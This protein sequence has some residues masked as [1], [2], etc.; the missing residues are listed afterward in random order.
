MRHCTVFPLRSLHEEQF[1]PTRDS[2][3]AFTLIEILVVVAIIALLV[4]VLLPSLARA[5]AQGRMALCQSHE[6][7]FGV[8]ATIFA[9]EHKNKIL[10]S[11]GTYSQQPANSGKYAN[12]Y[13]WLG[14]VARMLGDK[15]NYT[16]ANANKVPVEKMDVFQCP[17]RTLTHP[18]PYLDYVVNGLDSRGPINASCAPDITFGSWVEVTGAASLDLWKQPSDTIYITDAAR[19][20]EE[21]NGRQNAGRLYSGRTANPPDP[22]NFDVWT[23]GQVPAYPNPNGIDGLTI[24]PAAAL[25]MHLGRGSNS[26]FADGHVALVTPPPLVS[27]DADPKVRIL[28]F[29][30]R[31]FGVRSASMNNPIKKYDNATPS[32]FITCR[33]GD[34]YFVP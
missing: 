17:D 1:G 10:R 31:K 29:F 4:A 21:A 14:S 6:R 33:A 20:D 12:R 13:N 34:P 23:G 9:A 28:Q 7:Q 2:L 15:H 18:G 11:C 24:R 25:R 3:K 8:A 27:S 16:D 22:E 5:R 30:L 32:Y 26:V 19:E